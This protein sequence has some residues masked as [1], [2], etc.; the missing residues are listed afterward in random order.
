MLNEHWDQLITNEFPV[1]PKTFLNSLRA[2]GSFTILLHVR[3]RNGNQSECNSLRWRREEVVK[4]YISY[5]AF[6]LHY[7]MDKEG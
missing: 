5:I 6:Y 7:I 3:R 4:Q 2:R 1:Q